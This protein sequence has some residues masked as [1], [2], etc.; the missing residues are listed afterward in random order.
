MGGP[1]RGCATPEGRPCNRHQHR[2]CIAPAFTR[3]SD[4]HLQQ[5][6]DAHGEEG[7]VRGEATG[8]HGGLEGHAVQQA[9][10]AH[11]HQHRTPVLQATQ[12]CTRVS[13]AAVRS[14]AAT[15]SASHLVEGQQQRALRVQ[16]QH[17]GRRPVLK[18]KRGG[19]RCAQVH[20]RKHRESAT[21]RGGQPSGVSRRAVWRLLPPGKA[22]TRVTRLP[23]GLN[24]Q[25]SC[26]SSVP[27]RYGAPSRLEKEKSAILQGR[28]TSQG[29]TRG[30][31][32]WSTTLAH[33]AAAVLR[34][35]A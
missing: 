30:E 29:A 18:C 26:S 21:G 33:D 17:P 13:V 34:T 11:V 6:A 25:L 16:R 35:R 27:P 32:W 31:R 14:S 12:W 8:G 22:R 2:G 3:A 15:P 19:A 7:A 10:A 20:L 23:T 9:V 5:L 24:S 4:A 28:H 1:G